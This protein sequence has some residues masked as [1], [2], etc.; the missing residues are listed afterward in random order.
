MERMERLWHSLWH[1]KV[2]E[3]EGE[4]VERNGDVT[5]RVAGQILQK[6]DVQENQQ[7][8]D[9][10]RTHKQGDYAERKLNFIEHLLRFVASII[11]LCF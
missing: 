10:N 6:K 11:A 7:D 9:Q 2:K 5:D 8:Q 3:V 4:K 1:R